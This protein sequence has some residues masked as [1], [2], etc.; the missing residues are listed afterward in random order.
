MLIRINSKNP[1]PQSIRKIADLLKAGGVI[2]YP[3]DTVYSI[4]CDV[5]NSDAVERVAV[6]KGIP[7][8]KANFSFICSDFSHLSD[9]ALPI[10]NA[11]FKLMKKALPGPFTFILNA[12]N[13][14]PKIFKTK[15]RT[16]GIRVP[17]NHIIRTI[18]RALGN[19]VLSSSVH[20]DDELLE[21]STDPELIH[22]R[23]KNKV[24]LVVAG[25]F[26]NNEPSTIVDCTSSSIRILRQGMGI[27]EGY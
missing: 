25:E 7:V 3:T 10:D 16:I 4:G 21:Y 9:F 2:I 15:K 13:R 20:D 18:V 11:V 8:G 5:F 1:D 23:F 6:L 19:P 24:D 27:I 17:D 14:V 12:N 26:G 22:E